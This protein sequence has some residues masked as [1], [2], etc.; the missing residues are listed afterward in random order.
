VGAPASSAATSPLATRLPHSVLSPLPI[1]G[2][3]Q[4]NVELFLKKY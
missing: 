3:L 2:V 1:V 4:K